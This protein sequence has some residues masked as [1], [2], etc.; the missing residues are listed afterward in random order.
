MISKICIAGVKSKFYF[1]LDLIEINMFIK[2]K[3]ATNKKSKL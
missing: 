2:T 1:F 3:N